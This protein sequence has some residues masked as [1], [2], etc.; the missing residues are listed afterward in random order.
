MHMCSRSKEESLTIDNPVSSEKDFRDLN[1]IDP[2]WESDKDRKFTHN[3]WYPGS[4]IK[5]KKF[6]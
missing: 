4:E 3:I 6:Y 5:E 1:K 2:F